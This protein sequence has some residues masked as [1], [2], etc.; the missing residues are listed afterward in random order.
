MSLDIFGNT[1]ARAI[2]ARASFLLLLFLNHLLYKPINGIIEFLNGFIVIIARRINDTV[3]DVVFH[4]NAAHAFNGSVNRCQLYQHFTA[5][6]A[7]FYHS[8]NRFQM[9][10]NA[11]N[12]VQYGFRVFVAMCVTM[13][14]VMTVVVTMFMRVFM[15]VC[16]CMFVAVLVLHRF[17][18]LLSVPIA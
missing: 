13:F 2:P 10:H 9:A 14:V 3:L 4:D 6:A 11:I 1:K 18:P 15:V 16:M 7:V 8:F 17:R 12:A 5:I